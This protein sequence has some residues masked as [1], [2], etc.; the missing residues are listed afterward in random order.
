VLQTALADFYVEYTLLVA[1]ERP[2]DRLAVLSTLHAHVQDAFNE[3]GVQIMSPNY[4]A[5]PEQPKL[6]PRDRWFA[7]PAKPDRAE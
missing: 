1:P 7:A 3:H 2:E 4:E 6:V 5:D